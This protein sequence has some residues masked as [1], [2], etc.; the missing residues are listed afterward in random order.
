MVKPNPTRAREN[1]MVVKILVGV[2]R[3]TRASA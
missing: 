1:R 3:G 2:F